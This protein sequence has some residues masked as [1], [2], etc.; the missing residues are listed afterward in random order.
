MGATSEDERDYVFSLE[1]GLIPLAAFAGSLI[2]GLLPALFATAMHASLYQ[3]EPYRYPLFVAAGLVVAGALALLATE[4]PVSGRF[5]HTVSATGPLPLAPIAI[6]SLVYL[7]RS[8]GEAATI[9]FFNVYLDAGLHVSTAV[10]G[11]VMSTAQL[12][13]APAAMAAPL[14]IAR[15]GRAGTVGLAFLG[16]VLSLL[17]MAL[18][19]HWFVASL[20]L[21]C[22]KAMLSL[23]SPAFILLCQE[24]VP[25][26]WRPAMSGAI[27]MGQGVSMS[28]LALSGGYAI[29]AFGYRSPFSIAAALAVAG[30][31]LFW[32]FFLRTPRRKVAE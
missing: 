28:A 26:G 13:G 2:A 7:L 30:G 21:A 22:F 29:A 16:L 14:V 24:A 10:I 6:L 31:V 9:T 23:M 18:V 1:S 12:L 17:P 5:R 20:G 11:T 25:P 27:T 8:A 3:P 15:R 19:P 32:A 4:R